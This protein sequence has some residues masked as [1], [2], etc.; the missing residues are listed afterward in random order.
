MLRQRV[1]C[2]API[3][4]PLGDAAVGFMLA[5]RADRSATVS[6]LHAGTIVAAAE[7]PRISIHP[8]FW[9]I[10]IGRDGGSPIST[11]YRAP[12]AVPSGVLGKVIVDFLD[13]LTAEELALA[14]EATE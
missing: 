7:I 5:C 1:R 12:F 4:A 14:H 6:L 8:S 3:D 13:G 10:D 9:G 11:H 2:I